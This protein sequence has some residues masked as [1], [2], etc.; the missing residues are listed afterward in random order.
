[1][2]HPFIAG[3]WKMFK[4]VHDTVVYVKEFRSL[5]KD[6]EDVEIV[7]APPFTAVHAAAEAARNS[8][9]RRG[10]AEPPLGA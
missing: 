10:R 6:I 4:T 3:N 8:T 5:V 7:I 1:M 2:R 9:H